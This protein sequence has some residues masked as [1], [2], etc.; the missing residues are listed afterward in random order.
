MNKFY[1]IVLVIV[2]VIILL[3]LLVSCN[4]KKPDRDDN[5]QTG[6]H[7]DYSDPNAPKTIESKEIT[8][9]TYSFF[10]HSSD[11][12]WDFDDES[13]REILYNNCTFSLER[14][15]EGARCIGSGYSQYGDDT[16]DFEFLA[17][18]SALDDLQSIIDQ[19]K[20]ATSNGIHERTIGIPEGLGA[21][22]TVKYAS[23]ERID[24]YDNAGPVIN[25]DANLALYN[26]FIDLAREEKVM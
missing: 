13:Y 15:E 17:D 22:L 24:A 3:F 7:V 2:I 5:I 6:G 9:F 25:K 21:D 20:L 14:E 8:S 23:G 10:I 11:Y 4:S 18:L 12:E 16:F 19:Y 1:F 26:F